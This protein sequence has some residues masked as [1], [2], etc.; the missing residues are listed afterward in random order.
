M[1]GQLAAAIKYRRNWNRDWE[2]K[3]D[4]VT[5]DRFATRFAHA[6]ELDKPL[7][8]P[9][10]DA[11]RVVAELKNQSI[12]AWVHIGPTG[13]VFVAVACTPENIQKLTA[14]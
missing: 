12:D 9:I 10:E 13:A 8:D 5:T 6:W 1:K 14:V 2:R 7:N 11:R 4:F 3:V